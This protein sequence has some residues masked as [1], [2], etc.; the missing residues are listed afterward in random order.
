MPRPRPP[1]CPREG[2]RERE[3]APATPHGQRS[4]GVGG[5]H[6]D[7]QPACGQLAGVAAV[8]GSV[9]VRMRHRV[10]PG[11]LG[12]CPERTEAAKKPRSRRRDPSHP[13]VDDSPILLHRNFNNWPSRQALAL[14][15]RDK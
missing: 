8:S 15:F 3:N 7:S 10:V 1:G 5:F 6:P 11:R 4:R 2:G 12:S 13:S 9:R 14:R